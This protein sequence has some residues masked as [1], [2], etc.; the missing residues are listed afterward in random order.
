MTLA[1]EDAV[2][3]PFGT[4]GGLLAPELVSPYGLVP[5][6]ELSNSGII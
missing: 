4:Y 3:L 5:F 6:E 2:A 1:I